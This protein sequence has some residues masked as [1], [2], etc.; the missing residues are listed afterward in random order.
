[1]PE[2]AT[3]PAPQ[4]AAARRSQRVFLSLPVDIVWSSGAGLRVRESGSTE[5]VSQHGALVKMDTSLPIQMQVELVRTATGRISR[6]RVV[7]SQKGQ[8]GLAHVAV[9]LAV[10][11]AD[12]W[13]VGFPTQ[14]P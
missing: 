1:M 8:D 12:F 6:A 11:S 10:P 5:V 4:G 2:P 7:T 13:G 9:E 3:Q 14:K